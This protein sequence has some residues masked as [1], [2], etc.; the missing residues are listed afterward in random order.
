MLSGLSSLLRIGGAGRFGVTSP[1][2]GNPMP[3]AQPGFAPRPGGM[4]VHYPGAFNS[5]PMGG[6]PQ[7]VMGGVQPVW[8]SGPQMWNGPTFNTRP[9]PMPAP[10]RFPQFNFG[11]QNQM[12]PGRPAY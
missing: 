3:I 1:M 4:P 6:N 5:Q 10:T 9:A 11:A 7:P 8:G 12:R 2:A